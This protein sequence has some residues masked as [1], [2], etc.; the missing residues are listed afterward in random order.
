MKKAKPKRA[1]KAAPPVRS[2]I[3]R[4]AMKICRAVYAGGKCACE[5]SLHPVCPSMRKAAI[6][7]AGE[8]APNDIGRLTKESA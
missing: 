2:T 6:L 4:A 1:P 7:A 3:D 8:I 5:T